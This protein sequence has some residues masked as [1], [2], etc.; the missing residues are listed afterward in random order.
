MK[1]FRFLLGFAVLCSSLLVVSIETEAKVLSKPN[2]RDMR[3]VST[4]RDALSL[5]RKT[6][7]RFHGPT[8]SKRKSQTLQRLWSR[9]NPCVVIPDDLEGF[10]GCFAGCLRSWGL[11]YKSGTA[12]G[13]LCVAAATGNPVA[14]VGCAAC[15][16]TAEWIVGGCAMKCVWSP[17]FLPDDGPVTKGPRHPRQRRTTDQARLRVISGVSGS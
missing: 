15:L 1:P 3:G 17:S 11:D 6:R 14:I 9:A 4:G 8:L 2:T 13:T 16:G 7:A 12:C 5:V 10:S